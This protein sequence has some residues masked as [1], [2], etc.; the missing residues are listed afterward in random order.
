M[1]SQDRFFD[2]SPKP[3]TQPDRT[4]T[5]WR[6]A[7]RVLNSRRKSIGRNGPRE[8]TARPE[9]DK[10]T[11]CYGSG[12]RKNNDSRSS[13]CGRG[14]HRNDFA[15]AKFQL[16]SEPENTGAGTGGHPPP[17]ISPQCAG[18][19]DSQTTRRNGLL[20][21]EQPRFSPSISCSNSAGR[22]ILCQR[23][24]TA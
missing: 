18:P 8:A 4:H 16:S 22:R 7:Y 23:P 13:A 9:T 14:G 19:P 17:R 10:G 1:A 12:S 24:E 6:A 5:L 15:R 3:Y 20:S 11:H 2:V 21:P